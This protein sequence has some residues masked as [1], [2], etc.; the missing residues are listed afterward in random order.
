MNYIIEGDTKTH[1]VPEPSDAGP[2]LQSR[3]FVGLM[4]LLPIKKRLASAA[5]VQKQV[6]K[7]ALHPASYRPK[8]LGHGVAVTLKNKNG[9]PVYYT[10]PAENTHAGDW[11]VFLHGGGYINEI[12]Q[13]HWRFI[14]FLTRAAKVRC[15]VPIYPLA[16]GATA[17]DVVPAMGELLREIIEQAGTAKVT[18]MGNSAGAG[19]ALAACQWLNKEGYRQPD[20]LV[21]I[22][23][24]VDASLRFPG[25][26][27]IADRDPIQAIPGILEAARLYAGDLDTAHPYVSPLNGNFNGLSKMLIFSGTLDLH[28]PGSIALAEKARAAGVPVEL[29]LKTDQP[30]NYAAMPTPE[31]REARATILHFLADDDYK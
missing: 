16:P 29:H 18:V 12:V 11:V 13:A 14:G 28:Y 9:W 3:F 17:G 2:S 27:A 22:S 6:R 1:L 8:G 26:Q 24:G 7:L 19:L 5:A 30:H 4:H 31:G 20:G 23:P 10:T 21:L 15:I 25:Q